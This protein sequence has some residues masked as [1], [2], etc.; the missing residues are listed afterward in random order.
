M[1]A[2][3]RDGGRAARGRARPEH[4]FGAVFT[5]CFLLFSWEAVA[6]ASGSGWVQGL[7]AVAAG[8]ALVGLAGPGFALRRVKLTV[9]EAPADAGV[10][11]PFSLTVVTTRPCR[12]RAVAPAGT[13]TMLLPGRPTRV[14]LRADRRG[15]LSGVEV[16]VASAA[17]FGL[18][19]WSAPCYLRLPQQVTIAPAPVTGDHLV[20]GALSEHEGLEQA[21]R[22]EQG[23]QRGIRE[24]R[25]GDSMRRVH[26]R[27]SA[28][29]GSLM[30]RELESLLERP[31]HVVADLSDDVETA[32]LEA[33]RAMGAI[34]LLLESRALVVLET[35]AT[36]GEKVS[37]LVED[38]RAAGRQLAQARPNPWSAP[39][40]APCGP[41]DGQGGRSRTREA[42]P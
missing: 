25:A 5:A 24:Y 35:T 3:S 18:V 7:G 11:Q 36:N 33:G 40:L 4:A 16:N 8:V 39:G 22:A 41:Q 32:E 34:K 27:A 26:W 31:Y 42:S 12:W 23:E 21:M 38:E 29:T 1:S 14:E 9:T 17:P 19:W 10:G 20:D 13:T 2:V 37:A 28:H 15:V 30:V 6:H